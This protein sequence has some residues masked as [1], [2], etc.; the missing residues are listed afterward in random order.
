MRLTR[1][2]EKAKGKVNST[3][4]AVR[5]R[6]DST[7]N[8]VLGRADSTKSAVLGQVESV[9]GKHNWFKDALTRGDKEVP[10]HQWWLKKLSKGWAKFESGENE[11]MPALK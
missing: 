7:K 8:A 4:S 5:E 6:A 9:K 11:R 1:K 10:Q 3:T 2:T